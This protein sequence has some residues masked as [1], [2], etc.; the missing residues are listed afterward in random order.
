MSY[1]NIN[2]TLIF[3]TFIYI[4][5]YML[6]KWLNRM[7]FLGGGFVALGL[8]GRFCTFVVD[9]GEKAL[10]FDAIF[11]RGVGKKVL[12]EGIHFRFPYIYEPIIFNVRM[13]PHVIESRCPA[14]D[15][16]D[17]SIGVRILERPDVQFLRKLYLDQR[18][19]YADRVLPNITHEIIKT[20]VARYNPD[21]LI[22]QR[23]KVSSEIKQQLVAK[24]LEFNILLDDVAILHIEFSKEYRSA[25]EFKLVSQ[26]MAER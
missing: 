7:I 16:Q 4:F 15:L 23:E 8:S 12:G 25:I 20:V 6:G 11:G 19:N 22:T 3:C 21:Q 24:A 5:K 18:Q 1:V 2:M 26:Q 10:M 14:R 9:P 13:T 17:I